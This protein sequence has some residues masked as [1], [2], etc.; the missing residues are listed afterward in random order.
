LNDSKGISASP[1]FELRRGR[2]TYPL[3]VNSQK[4]VRSETG[5]LGIPRKRSR[6]T[7]VQ[8]LLRHLIRLKE[9]AT[10]DHSRRGEFD[11]SHAGAADVPGQS[12]WAQRSERRSKCGECRSA[13]SRR[14]QLRLLPSQGRTLP[15]IK[16]LRLPVIVEVDR[17]QLRSWRNSA[18][19][20]SSLS[21]GKRWHAR[22]LERRRCSAE[23]L[24]Y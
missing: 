1:S 23:A 10:R 14:I 2:H 8:A 5:R 16:S 4:Y 9:P 24:R 17:S 21:A 11:P 13:R 22:G 15:G 19:D 12:Q 3:E 7:K 18:R 6:R 20:L